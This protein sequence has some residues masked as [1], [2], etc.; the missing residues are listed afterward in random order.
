MFFWTVRIRRLLAAALC[1]LIGLTAISIFAVHSRAAEDYIKYV[2][3]NVPYAALH[4][5]MEADI[6][7]KG[8]ISW[9]DT[10]SYLAAKYGGEWKR[11]KAADMDA[12]LK[13]LGNGEKLDD[14][15]RDMKYFS[16]FH[17]AYDAV[18]GG[19]LGDYVQELPAGEGKDPV[20]QARYGLRAYSP[21]AEGYY[22]NDFDDFGA[23]RTYGFARQ[24][25]GHDLMGS[26]GTPVIAVESGTIEIMGWNQYG[27][28]R[29]G[30]RSADK[31]RYWYYAHLRK[32]HPF[33]ADLKEGDSVTAGQ[34][35]G[36]L[37][38]TGYSRKENVN[39]IKTPHLHYGLELVFNEKQ[40][41]S[42]NEIWVD[43]YALTRLL[44]EHRSTVYREDKEFY[45]KYDMIWCGV[46]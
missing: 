39:G 6:A 11:Y 22:Y 37:G 36:Y 8:K 14:L 21:I 3:F 32:D 40:K 41:E 9:V 38:Q 26:V 2:E 35:I 12:L 42:S 20:W 23:S 25:M 34:V 24:H 16:Y 18:L 15:T 44:S 45:R 27:G 13:K 29:I 7:C 28:W 30:I 19:L 4:K 33:H 5:A 1:L 17:Q 43:L 10:L 31:K 46:E